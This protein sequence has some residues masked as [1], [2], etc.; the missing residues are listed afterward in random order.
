LVWF[1]FLGQKPV[2]IGLV[3][4]FWFGLVFP[5]L[6]WFFQFGSVF[7]LFFFYLG[8]VRFGFF[9]FR[10]IKPNPTEPVGFFKILMDLIGFFSRFGFFDCFFSGFSV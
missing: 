1:G 5:G 4:F 2:Q 8:S 9:G 10:L 6:A 3:R 7:F